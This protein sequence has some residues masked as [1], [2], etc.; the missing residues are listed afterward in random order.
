MRRFRLRPVLCVLLATLGPAWADFP[1]PFDERATARLVVEALIKSAPDLEI[2]LGATTATVTAYR[3]GGPGHGFRLDR[4]HAQLRAEPDGARRQA[5]LDAYV[6]DE[7]AAMGAVEGGTARTALDAAAA[8]QTDTVLPILRPADPKAPWD[9]PSQ[10]HLPFAG[11][12]FVLWTQ[13]RTVDMAGVRMTPAPISAHAA[14]VLGLDKLDLQKLGRA[15]LEARLDRLTAR[16][17]GRLLIL[18]LDG[19]F[20]PSLMLVPRIWQGMTQKGQV[21]TAAL[22]DADELIVLA[23]ASTEEIAALRQ[24]L[25]ATADPAPLSPEL[26]R[27]T[28]SDWQVLPP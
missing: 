13:D 2:I 24:R 3:Q 25:Q 10:I 4:I 11:G 7:L 18:S 9:L 22:P 21:L 19:R 26:F 15:N 14:R 23:D 6:A 27:W 28:G 12:L 17:E 8:I 1:R 16:R 5:L 20:G